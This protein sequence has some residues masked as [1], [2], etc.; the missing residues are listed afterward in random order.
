MATV[1]C[2]QGFA[3]ERARPLPNQMQWNQLLR[4]YF[5]A[6]SGCEVWS[7]AG[8]G[9]VDDARPEVD[10]ASDGLGLLEA[11]L[12]EPVGD[13]ERAGAVVAHDGDG[14]FFVEL[15]EGARADLIHGHEDAVGEVRGGVLP[16]LADVEQKRRVLGGELLFELVDGDLKFHGLRIKDGVRLPNV[17][18]DL[19]GLMRVA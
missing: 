17:V 18:R 1:L 6:I 11:L 3:R 15:V 7:V 2:M 14:L 13:G 12:A 10:A 16:G 5:R 19:R 4:Y 9:G 8:D